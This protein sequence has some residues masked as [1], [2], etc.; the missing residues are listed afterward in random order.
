MYN[1]VTH[2]SPTRASNATEG[3]PQS[4]MPS[5]SLSPYHTGSWPPHPA[6]HKTVMT[7]NNNDTPQKV[8]TQ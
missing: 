6:V 3:T 4:G 8:I 7:M 2:I 5:L 1:D